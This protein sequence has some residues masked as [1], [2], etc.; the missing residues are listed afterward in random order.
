MKQYSAD[1]RELLLGVIAAG[2]PLAEAARLFR[3]CLST[4]VRWR[5]RQRTTGAVAARSRPG[6][7]P[8]IGSAHSA[9]LQAQV[10]APPDATLAQHCAHCATDHGVP[11]SLATMSR[12][13]H[14]LGITVKKSPARS[15]AGRGGTRRWCAETAHLDPTPL[16]FV[17]ESG[18]NLAFTPRYARAPRAQ[19]VVAVVPRNHCPN[20]T[21]L[22]A[23]S[24]SLITSSIT[25]TSPTY[26]S[27]FSLFLSHILLPSL[28]PP[29][30]FI[31]YNLPLSS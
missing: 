22:A 30:F 6:R 18:T 9:A 24:H 26:P 12:F 29:H 25:I 5:Q 4:I 28:Q 14:R 13:I 21:L 16:V 7:P 10:A 3:V 31:S 8:R 27:L 11:V 2:L 17:D 15:R 20:V 23:M 19:R 1:F